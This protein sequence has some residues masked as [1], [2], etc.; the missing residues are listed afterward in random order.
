[1]RIRSQQVKYTSKGA[2][3]R[4]HNRIIYL[5]EFI[6]PRYPEYTE[7][8]TFHG[9]IVHGILPLVYDLGIGVSISDDGE[10]AKVFYIM[11]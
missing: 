2:Y 1:M 7:D 8:V 3:V 9:L 5:A 4:Y 10:T 11:S 6:R